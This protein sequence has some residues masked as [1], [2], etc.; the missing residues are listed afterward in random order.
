[1]KAKRIIFAVLCVLL[2]LVIIMTGI[3][4]R[5]VL[6]L[7]QWSQPPVS[8]T[9]PSGNASTPSGETH[10]TSAP[11]DD[12]TAP[13]E[14]EHVHEFILTDSIPATCEG[15]GWNI[16]T[17]STCGY[18]NMPSNERENP[19][20]HSY[21]H[22][23]VIAPTCTEGGY[24]EFICTRC[25]KVVVKDETDPL[26]HQFDE[27]TEVPATCTEN[28]H[29]LFRCL[30][31]GCTETKIENIQESTMTEHTYGPWT[32]LETG[33]AVQYCEGCGKVRYSSEIEDPE[34]KTIL[35]VQETSWTDQYGQSGTSYLI[36]VGVEGKPEAGIRT[37]T[38]YDYLNNGT[39]AFY[40]DEQKGLV[41]QFVDPDGMDQAYSLTGESL[42]IQADGSVAGG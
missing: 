21:D 15:Y 13:T 20:G 36:T 29:T 22:G 19:L 10:N 23:Q 37:Y 3:I 25:I 40:Y 24:T 5:R 39:I 33:E 32:Y 38:V 18:V 12:S 31:E 7:Y 9:S 17:C 11:T 6:R 16:Y 4:I 14:S 42:T 26:G 1:M 28:A 27:G 34:V 2:V 41:V 35:S 30:N 8:T